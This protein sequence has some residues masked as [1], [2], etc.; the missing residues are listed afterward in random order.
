[1]HALSGGMYRGSSSFGV[2]AGWF[3]WGWGS[4]MLLVHMVEFSGDR[5]HLFL[6]FADSI[7][8]C[9]L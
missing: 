1:M 2:V 6:Q 7:C 9:S 4:R 5:G 8:A 3:L